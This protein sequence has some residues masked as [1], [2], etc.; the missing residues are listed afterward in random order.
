[1]TDGLDDK[2]FDYCSHCDQGFSNYEGYVCGSYICQTC[3]VREN[4]DICTTYST[5]E[6]CKNEYNLKQ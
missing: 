5:C 1:M 3:K 4:C 6:K 2:E